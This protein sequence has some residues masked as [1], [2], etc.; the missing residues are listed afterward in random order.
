MSE[1]CK[2]ADAVVEGF[3]ECNQTKQCKIIENYETIYREKKREG[4]REGKIF[5]GGIYI[6]I[7]IE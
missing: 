3:V 2:V 5:Y 7:I 4:G 6:Y 1:A